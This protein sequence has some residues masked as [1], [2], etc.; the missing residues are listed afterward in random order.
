MKLKNKN[1]APVGGY[2]FKYEINKSG[3]TFQ[4]VVHGQSWS[5]L[6]QNIKREYSANSLELPDNIEQIVE[7]Q[8]CQRQPG[9]RCWYSDGIGDRIAQAIHKVANVADKVLGTK[10][11]K[12]ARGCS[13]CNR[14]RNALNS[15]S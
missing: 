13:A 3:K 8:I 15:L 14:R 10:L 1:L 5:G 12:K 4:A 7:D 9:D 11:E 2:Y 6:I